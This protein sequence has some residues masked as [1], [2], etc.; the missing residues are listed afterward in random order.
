[1]LPLAGASHFRSGSTAYGIV[2]D[3]CLPHDTHFAITYQTESG[4]YPPE[5]LLHGLS[6]EDVVKGQS[7]PELARVRKMLG[8][9]PDA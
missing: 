9:D 1:L 4:I 8:R 6:A 3:R 7:E 5:E 2:R